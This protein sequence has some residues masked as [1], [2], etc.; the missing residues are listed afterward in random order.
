MTTTR[1]RYTVYHALD[2]MQM[3]FFDA[4][5]WVAGRDIN[6]RRVAEVVVSSDEE[7]PLERVFRLTNHFDGSWTRNPD[8]AWFTTDAPVRSTSTGDVI[9]CKDN[10]QAWIVIPFGFELLPPDGADHPQGPPP[11]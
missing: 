9:V 6:Y 8:V 2:P 5:Q 10:P 7:N 1:T 11:E 3:V 4:A